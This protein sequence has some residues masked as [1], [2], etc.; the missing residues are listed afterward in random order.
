VN[1]SI[2][3]IDDI[4]AWKNQRNEILKDIPDVHV[5]NARLERLATEGVK[6]YKEYSKAAK[7]FKASLNPAGC[8]PGG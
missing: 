4:R 7:S 2:N 8:K 3:L 5:S 6:L 1:F